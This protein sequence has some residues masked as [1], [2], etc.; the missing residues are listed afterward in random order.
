MCVPDLQLRVWFEHSGR[1]MSPAWRVAAVRGCA[2]ELISSVANVLGFGVEEMVNF[3]DATRS[4]VR[5][6]AA[7]PVV[8]RMAARVFREEFSLASD[9]DSVPLERLL[10]HHY[11]VW[12]NLHDRINH[13]SPN[14][15]LQRGGLY[16]FYDFVAKHINKRDPV[17][18][19]DIGA[20]DCYLDF[21][22][23]EDMHA[24][25]R[26]DC[27]DIKRPKRLHVT[28]RISFIEKDALSMLSDIRFEQ[29]DYAVLSGFLGLL[30]GDQTSRVLNAVR[31]CPRLFIRENPKITNLIDAWNTS[32]PDSYREY[33]HL[34]T[35]Q[36]LKETLAAHGFDI[37]AMEHEY[38]IYVFA[39]SRVIGS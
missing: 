31:R 7:T 12:R 2:E 25:T 39:S 1:P 13:A 32:L 16:S 10:R 38:D 23:S 9:L 37:L 11:E 5:R 17:R 18:V 30:S 27:V 20:G 24:D 28:P 3:R 14:F 4:A 29:Y 35:E 19:V 22:L 26:F 21:M 8:R 15:K 36:S 6:L 33:P 34:F